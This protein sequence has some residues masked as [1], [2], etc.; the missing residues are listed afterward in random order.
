MPRQDGIGFHLDVLPSVPDPRPPLDT[1]IAITNKQGNVYT[2]SAS[3]PKGYGLWF[4]RQNK[5]AFE[6]VRTAQ[7]RAILVESANIYASIDDVPDAL[8]HTSL[9]R[10]IQLMK[11]HRDIMFDKEQ[12]NKY[13]P[14]S[15]IITTLAAQ[16]Y[17]N[18]PD[19]YSALY[20]IVTQ[21]H[22]HAVLVENGTVNRSLVPHS[23]IKRS[24]DGGWYIGNPVNPKEN[25]AD[26]WQE[27]NHARARAFFSLG[28][29]VKRNPFSIFWKSHTSM[30][31]ANSFLRRS[32]R[33]LSPNIST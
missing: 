27:D 23:P 28:C 2:W 33:R 10:S 5:A 24:P 9:Q 26:R 21:L 4:D 14:I 6:F 30:F 18:E 7:K 29:G 32:V 8:V 15:V 11:R 12:N 16:F 13:A 3:D 20:N 19:I 22:A 1:A 25:F 31:C 17:Q